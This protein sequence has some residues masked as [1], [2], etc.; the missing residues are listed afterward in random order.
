MLHDWAESKTMKAGISL[1]MYLDTAVLPMSGYVG[2]YGN[3]EGEAQ[4]EV[5]VLKHPEW[6]RIEWQYNSDEIILLTLAFW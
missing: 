2:S 1:S 4:N 5:A 3:A 6:C